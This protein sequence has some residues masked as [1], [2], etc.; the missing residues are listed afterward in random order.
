[1]VETYAPL[2][3]RWLNRYDVQ[4]SDVED[5]VQEVLLALTR[6]IG[7]FQH[8]SHPG[9]FRRWLR[10]I[11]VHRL[12]MFWRARDRRRLLA[13]DSSLDDLADAASE[14]AREWDLEH[15]QHVMRHL[16]SIVEPKF[17]AVTY[18]AFQMQ[19]VDGLSAAEVSAA[20]GMSMG[21]AYAAKSRVLAAL[22]QEAGGLLD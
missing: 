2:L 1:M 15:D 9:A 5:L 11:L 4:D 16:L 13:T 14:I 19:A 20:L 21:S 7:G 22:R 3:R 6:E 10:T 8:N 17:E 18:R 12:K